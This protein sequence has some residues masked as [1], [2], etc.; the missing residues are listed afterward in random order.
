M[1]LVVVTFLFVGL[2]LYEA[3]VFNLR[4]KNEDRR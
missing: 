4:R 1:I 3:D 2:C